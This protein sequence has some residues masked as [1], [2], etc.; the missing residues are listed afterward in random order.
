MVMQ[1]ILVVIHKFPEV[2]VLFQLVIK[3]LV[4]IE[5]LW[6]LKIAS[7]ET[8]VQLGKDGQNWPKSAWR[9]LQNLSARA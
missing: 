7:S 8:E 6:Q 2:M 9:V 4:G 1:A 3:P 5:L